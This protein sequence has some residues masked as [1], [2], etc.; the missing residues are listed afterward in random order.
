MTTFVVESRRLTSMPSMPEMPD[1]GEHHG[2]PGVVGGLDDFAVAYRAAGLNHGG[3]AGVDRDQPAI[4]KRNRCVRRHPGRPGHR[5]RELSI[6]CAYPR[7][8]RAER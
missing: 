8:A 3:G 7:P 1:A 4:G 2:D 5:V 6:I